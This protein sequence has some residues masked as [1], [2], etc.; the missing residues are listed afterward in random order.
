ML[1][2]I[3]NMFSSDMLSKRTEIS[4][5][6]NSNFNCNCNCSCNSNCN[7]KCSCNCNSRCSRSCNCDCSCSCNC[8]CYCGCYPFF[9]W[10][11]G[12]HQCTNY[13]LDSYYCSTCRGSWATNAES[14]RVNLLQK[15]TQIHK[16]HSHKYA[17]IQT[18]LHTHIDTHIEIY[19]NKFKYIQLLV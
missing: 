6:G 11:L 2:L 7:C 19:T 8:S 18:R 9:G 3:D 10:T 13:N 17:Y 12:H 15:H 1:Y 4:H 16:L 14:G 5:R